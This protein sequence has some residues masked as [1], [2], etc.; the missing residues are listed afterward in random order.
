MKIIL[1]NPLSGLQVRGISK[2]ADELAMHLSK[3]GHKVI[4]IKIR[5]SLYPNSNLLKI[6]IFILYQQIV[7]PIIAIKQKAD[8]II[9]PYNGFSV[10]GSLLIRTK[11][12]IHDYTPFKRRFWYLRPG[13]I[14]QLL[15][16][17]FDSWFSLAEM[18]HDSLN[19]DTPNFLKRAKS[20]KFFPC[21]VDELERTNSTFFDDITR[22]FN[23]AQEDNVLIISTISGPGW[24]KDF[25]GLVENLK[26]ISQRF[27]LIAFG[28]GEA[29]NNCEEVVMKNGAVSRVLRIGFV[30]ESSI[31][32]AITKS[33]LFVFHSLSEGFG[34]PI[35]EA[36]Q[37]KKNIV[38]TN[39]APVLNILSDEAMSN[40]FVYESSD[41]FLMAIDQAMSSSFK[42]FK[43]TYKPDIDDSLERFLS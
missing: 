30:E 20:P 40:I 12:F 29:K 15:M 26:K 34:R 35:L 10:L 28:F 38:S 42:P 37:L 7:C 21:I 32:S 33:D 3:A 25:S 39:N 19:I 18:Y 31:S 8:L 6:L 13:T 23:D 1:F 16:F 22:P 17:K 2:V 27:I 14:Y 36:L 9:D 43:Q 11:Y 4:E 5:K 24:N 41:E